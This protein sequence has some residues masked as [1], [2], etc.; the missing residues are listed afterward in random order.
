[1]QIATTQPIAIFPTHYLLCPHDA[2]DEAQ[3]RFLLGVLMRGEVTKPLVLGYIELDPF[4]SH[5][6]RCRI[7][8]K[9]PGLQDVP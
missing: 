9:N 6:K 4:K 7:R 1:M 5:S 2:K 3:A 8:L